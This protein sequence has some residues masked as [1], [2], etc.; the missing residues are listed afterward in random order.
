M[1]Y[2]IV[3]HRPSYG[4]TSN[5]FRSFQVTSSSNG[6]GNIQLAR[7]DVHAEAVSPSGRRYAV[8]VTQKADGTYSANFTP[9]ESGKCRN[10]V[11]YFH[12][13]T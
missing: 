11:R 9:S 4:G 1:S 13:A 6:P 3:D 5:T 8:D 7:G 10:G 2:R 12:I